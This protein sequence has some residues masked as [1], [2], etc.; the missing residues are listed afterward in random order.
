MVYLTSAQADETF[1]FSSP[2]LPGNLEE[3]Q[4]QDYVDQRVEEVIATLNDSQ[5]VT[6]FRLMTGEE[7]ECFVRGFHKHNLMSPEDYDA[8]VGFRH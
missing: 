1:I 5:G 6:D 7:V 4:V 3:R 8:D 2:R